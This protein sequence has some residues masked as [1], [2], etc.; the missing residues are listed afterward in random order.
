[1]SGAPLDRRLARLARTGSPGMVARSVRRELTWRLAE[2]RLA[3][4]ARRSE[5]VLA[6]PFVG[7]VGYELLYWIAFLRFLCRRYGLPRER[8]TVVTRGG[9][10]LWYR[11]LAADSLEVLDL[12][13]ADEYV[14]RLAGQREAARQAKQEAMGDLDR[15]LLA[16]ARARI[17]PAT[18]VH[19]LL[20]YARLRFFWE[21]LMGVDALLGQTDHRRLDVEPARFPE[22]P[23]SY[24]A[25]K[26]YF[27]ECLPETAGTRRSMEALV[28]RLAERTDVVVLSS[29]RQL[30]DHVE[31]RQHAERVHDASR[32]LEPRD[33]L[34]VQARIV[35]GAQALVSTYGGFSYLGP[36]VGTPTLAVRV[37][38]P[39]NARHREVMRAAGTGVPYRTARL[40]HEEALLERLLAPARRRAEIAE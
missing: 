32:W 12:M 30:D 21:G 3:R 38:A 9:A 29:G 23:E 34:A 15:E 22:L 27:N 26:L 36:F 20:M 19:P 11:D 18:A 10:G 14:A 28:D 35:A 5:P 31:W 39:D 8:V 17:G 16:R 1:V 40:G 6:G 13:D 7:E 33:N 37:G 25:V 2:A 24:V 4:A